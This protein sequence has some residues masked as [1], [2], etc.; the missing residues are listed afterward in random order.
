[1]VSDEKTVQRYAQ[2]HSEMLAMLDNLKEFVASMPAPDENAVIPGVDYGYVG[3]V[4]RI[5]ELLK[6]ASDFAYEMTE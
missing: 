6:Q 3:E 4:G 2:Q 5:H 1:M